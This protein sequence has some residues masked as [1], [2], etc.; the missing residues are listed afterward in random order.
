MQKEY[1]LVS[2]I[3]PIYNMQAYL[4]E[5]IESVLAS[6]YPNFEVIL[7]DDGSTDNSKDIALK[8][9]AKDARLKF[10]DQPN[11][12]SSKARN[13]AIEVSQGEY[14]LPVDAD[15]LISPDYIDK[16]VAILEHESNVKIVYCEAVFFGDKK[17]PWKLPHYSLGLLARKNLMD[18]CAMYRRSDWAKAGGYCEDILGREDWDFWISMLKTGGDVFQLPI[19]GLH[20][21][22]T[23]NSKRKRTRHLKGVIIEQMNQRHKAFFYRQLGGKLRKSRTWSRVINFFVHL[24][25]PEHIVCHPIHKEFE[26]FVYTCP[27]RYSKNGAAYTYEMNGSELIITEYIEGNCFSNLFKGRFEKSKARTAYD[28]RSN[29]VGYYEI[30]TVFWLKKSYYVSLYEKKTALCPTEPKATLI[31]SVY[32]NLPF[33]KAVLDSLIYQTE[34]NFEIII[35][36][37]GKSDAVADFVNHYPFIHQWQHL[38]QEDEGWRKNKAMN[39][40]IKAAKADWLICIDGDCV[41]HPRFVEMHLRYADTNCVLAGKRVKLDTMASRPILDNISNISKMQ[42]VL[43]RKLF[44]GRGKM[45][46]I[47][48]GIFISPDRFLKFI[49]STRKLNRLKGCNMSFSKKAI[50]AINGFDEDFQLP[51]VGEDEDLSWRFRAAGFEHKSVRNMAVQYHL[52]HT[53]SWVD[54]EINR[55]ISA[56][57]QANNEF[58]CK[59][60]LGK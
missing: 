21:R 48:D 24:I 42:C 47:E 16:A 27:E 37:D 50:Y 57:K 3:I 4:S 40:A 44:L 9:V 53:E 17:G 8:Y 43:I 52:Y 15:N 30:S 29:A 12:G 56:N 55:A 14:I 22:V 1:P 54:Q 19:V 23:A 45:K 25:Y 41:L 20:Y 13:H 39:N 34:N 2:V 31:I 49:P 11:G 36:E 35:S 58:F 7:L 18:N 28:D 32:N 10:F 33:L 5:T 59:N 38:T 60:G 51:A 6:A 46:F 26:E